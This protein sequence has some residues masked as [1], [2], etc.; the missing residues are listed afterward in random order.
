VK[1]PVERNIGAAPGAD[2]VAVMPD[3]PDSLI[4]VRHGG[5]V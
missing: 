2:G 3:V 5:G 4:A 1:P